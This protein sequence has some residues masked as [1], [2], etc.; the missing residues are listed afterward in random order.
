MY[1]VINLTPQTVVAV[2]DANDATRLNWIG[3]ATESKIA[4]DDIIIQER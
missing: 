3:Q 4:D 1:S 2:A